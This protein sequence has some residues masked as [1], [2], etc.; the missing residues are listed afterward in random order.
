MC[1]LLCTCN[2]ANNLPESRIIFSFQ[3]WVVTFSIWQ[4]GDCG[5]QTYQTEMKLERATTVE[6][7]TITPICYIHCCVQLFIFLTGYFE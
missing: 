1:T 2:I 6:F 7:T 3:Q 5:L 4:V